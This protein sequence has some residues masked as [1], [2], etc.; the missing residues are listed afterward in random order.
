MIN[1]LA[2]TCVPLPPD[3]S[4]RKNAPAAQALSRF[5]HF[6]A[7][8]TRKRFV[9]FAKAQGFR[10]TVVSCLWPLIKLKWLLRYLAI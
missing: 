6:R 10:N 1:K 8:F 7:Y 4:H 3:D 5:F 2:A 9:M